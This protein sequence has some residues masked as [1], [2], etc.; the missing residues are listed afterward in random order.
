LLTSLESFQEV[1]EVGGGEFPLEGPRG[2]VVPL[3]EVG[4]A[5]LN[6][7]EVGEVLGESTFR[8]MIEK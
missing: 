8:W 2:G 7:V 3:L 5:L 4:E 6:G 1:G